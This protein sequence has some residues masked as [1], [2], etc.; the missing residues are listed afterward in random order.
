[1][2]DTGKSRY[3]AIEYANESKHLRW[4]INI[5]LYSSL[6]QLESDDCFD[7]TKMNELNE[8]LVRLDQFCFNLRDITDLACWGI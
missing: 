4:V 8:H 2:W 6:F 1:M 5:K 7:S 3:Q